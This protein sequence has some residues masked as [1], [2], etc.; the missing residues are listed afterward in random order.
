MKKQFVSKFT[1]F[2]AAVLLCCSS[3]FISSNAKAQAC[4]CITI[5]HSLTVFCD[6][7]WDS[8]WFVGMPPHE[9]ADTMIICDTC[10]TFAL[11]NNCSYGISALQL[12]DSGDGGGFKTVHHGC[13]EVENAAEDTSWVAMNFSDGSIMFQDTGNSCWEPG[14]TLL[15]S[16]CNPLVE[17]DTINVEWWTCSCPPPAIPHGPPPYTGSLCAEGF[18]PGG[19]RF[20]VP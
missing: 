10:W 8:I 6:T 13:A 12:F 1:V 4:N 16:I 5:S 19:I 7:C 11:T 9:H 15:V 14:A 3:L 2:A 20:I 18:C 17:G